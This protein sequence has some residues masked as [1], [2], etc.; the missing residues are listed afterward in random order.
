M[1]E[2]TGSRKIQK[3]EKEHRCWVIRT[4]ELSLII[5]DYLQR[6]ESKKWRCRSIK[7]SCWPLCLLHVSL[8]STFPFNPLKKKP[9]MARALDCL[10][11]DHLQVSISVYRNNTLNACPWPGLSPAA[12]YRPLQS[13]RPIDATAEAL[14]GDV[15]LDFIF[16]VF[17]SC[18]LV[19]TL[20]ACECHQCI[21]VKAQWNVSTEHACTLKTYWT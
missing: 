9:T 16:V 14:F 5:S 2:S 11:A 13:S 12:V 3:W 10:H 18:R 7:V 21:L 6:I 17:I 15:H 1:H 19:A 4:N 20:V 8:Q